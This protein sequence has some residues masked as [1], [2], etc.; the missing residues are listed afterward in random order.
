MKT[1]GKS[2]HERRAADILYLLSWN[3]YHNNI[4]IIRNDMSKSQMAM[5]L[6]L[7]HS[8]CILSM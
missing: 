2:A 8:A 6:R 3:L 5:R 4:I 7:R 1:S